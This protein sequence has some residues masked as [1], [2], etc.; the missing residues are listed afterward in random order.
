MSSAPAPSGATVNRQWRLA[1]RP[2]GLPQP[3]DWEFHT[4]P[5]P[6]PGEGDV[7]VRIRYI[8]LDPAMRG[9][10]NDRRSYV[11][12]VGLGEVM[13]AVGLGQ[14]LASRHPDFE[15]GDHVTGVFGV[16]DY[17]ISDGRG[18][19]RVQAA[20]APLTHYLSVLGVPGMTAYFGLL[21]IGRPVAG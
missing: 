10:M 20:A 4:E 13:R 3:N 5:V 14:V 6:E 1:A 7:L 8:S 17:A 16:Q 9:W 21:D 18:V 12:P 19:I 2:N 11:P 15:V